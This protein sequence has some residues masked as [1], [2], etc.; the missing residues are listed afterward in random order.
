MESQ[1]ALRFTSSSLFRLTLTVGLAVVISIVAVNL[2]A[3]NQRNHCEAYLEAPAGVTLVAHAGGGLQQGDYSNSKDALDQS[4][5]NGLRLFE[6]DFNWTAD[7]ELAIVHDWTREYRYWHH[8]G[9]TDWL[10]SHFVA[11]SS[12]RFHAST[13]RFGLSRL[14]LETLIEWLRTNPGRIITDIKGGNVEGLALVASLAG[15]LQNRFV[16]QIYSVA[17][18]DAVRQMGYE[19]II[20]TTYRLSLSPKSLREIDELDLF[21]VTVPENQVAAAAEIISKNR[22]FT[23][24]IN[25][26]VKLTAAGYYTDCLIPPEPRNGV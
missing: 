15:P 7:G 14:S 6:L 16:P 12:R 19:D 10:A 11:P 23:H 21:A 25:V 5:A 17:E 13:P 26:P 1:M 8:L 3:N 9:W 18:Y 22:I 20:L 24:T 4:A 2:R